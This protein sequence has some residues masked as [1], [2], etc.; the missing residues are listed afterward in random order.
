MQASGNTFLTG[1]LGH[2]KLK[3]V[4]R[5]LELCGIVEEV[6]VCRVKLAAFDDLAER[7]EG[8]VMVEDRRWSLRIQLA[9]YLIDLHGR[10]SSGR[11]QLH[12]CLGAN[13]LF[14]RSEVDGVEVST[15]RGGVD[16]K[17]SSR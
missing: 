1:R 5:V 16:C 15:C 17:T 12:R 4:N 7:A 13:G 8:G 10:Y 2:R 14:K 11:L 6:H 9:N 3:Q